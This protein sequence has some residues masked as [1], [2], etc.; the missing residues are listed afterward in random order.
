M[1]FKA[2]LDEDKIKKLAS[3]AKVFVY[4]EVD[5]TNN[6]ARKLAALGAE[7]G[8]IVIADGQRAGKGRNG[9]TFFSGR[10]TGIF[11]S[12][13]I[14]NCADYMLLTSAAAAAVCRACNKVCG[15][16]TQIKWVNDIYLDDKKVCGILT[17]AL[18][19]SDGELS[20]AIVGIGIN[21]LPTVFPPEIADIAT[22]LYDFAPP[23]GTSEVLVA[24]IFNQLMFF[25]ANIKSSKFLNVCR[26]QSNIIGKQVTVLTPSG[27]YTATALDIDDT[28]ALI[29]DRDGTQTRLA[30]GE[31]SIRL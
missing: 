4:D 31:V 9:K 20:G 27:K 14:K 8:T 21:F 29:V 23:A 1:R 17:E 19:D 11:I 26:A 2:L 22:S 5:S 15:V 16:S 28:G 13:I 25:A 3:S 18:N 6:K 7:H 12:I 30:T 24:E 10:G